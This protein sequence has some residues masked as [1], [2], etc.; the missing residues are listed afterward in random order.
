MKKSLGI[1]IP[2]LLVSILAH[3]EAVPQ[4]GSFP[5]T[6]VDTGVTTFYD[7]TSTIPTPKP[8]GEYFGQDAQYLCPLPSYK[9]NGDGTITD[10]I[11]GL[12]WQK[13]MGKKLPWLTSGRHR[14]SHELVK[15]C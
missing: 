1:L 11:T 8:G 9:D 2:V 6:I 12:M 13:T 5:Y 14:K 7:S 10:N 15:I 3:K 4:K